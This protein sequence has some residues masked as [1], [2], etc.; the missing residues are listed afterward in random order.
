MK[1]LEIIYKDGSSCDVGNRT[2]NNTIAMFKA[3][4]DSIN[5]KRVKTAILYVRSSPL[6]LIK[7]GIVINRLEET[8]IE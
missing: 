7:D 8:K 2:K 1:R 5:P 3:H 4:I 6:I